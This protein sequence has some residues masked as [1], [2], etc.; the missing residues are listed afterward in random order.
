MK[1]MKLAVKLASG[2]GILIA[3]AVILGGMSVWQMSKVGIEAGH[4][5]AENVPM[6]KASLEAERGIHEAR[7]DIRI[8]S[9]TGDEGCRMAGV[10]HMDLT[11]QKLKEAQE[12]ADKYPGLTLLRDNIRKAADKT[13]EY[14]ILIAETVSRNKALDMVHSRQNDSAAQFMA[15]CYAFLDSQNRK[16]AAD[17]QVISAAANLAE[18]VS[19]L[20]ERLRKVSLMNDIIDAGNRLRVAN[21]K[22]Q[23]LGD[24][25][26]TKTAM[27]DFDVI[28]TKCAELAPIV[29]TQANKD[30]LAVIR[31]AAEQYKEA[32]AD[33]VANRAA[34]TELDV[35]RNAL[36]DA[37]LEATNANAVACIEKVSAMA[38]QS[39]ANLD[40]AA[41]AMLIG[42]ALAILLG[43]FITIILTREITKPILKG[44]EFANELAKGNFSQRLEI[45][46]RDEIGI[47]A[48]SLNTVVENLQIQIREIKEAAN[49]LAASSSEISASVSQVTSGAQ[50]TAAAV[51]QTTATVEE[52]KQG[53]HLTSQ[54]TRTVAENSQKGLQLAH[55]G[56]KAT[57]TVAEGMTHIN[58]QMASIADTIVKLGEQSQMIGEI[59]STVDD[60]AEQSN[61]LA[62]NAAVEAA[63]A[64]E[65]GKGFAVVAQE[66]KA[67]AEQSKQAT[68]QV[69]GILHDIQKATG[70]AVMATEQGSKAVEQGTK[71]SMSANES[72]QTLSLSFTETVQS[73]GQIAASTQEQ[74]TGMDQVALAMESIKEASQQNVASMKQLETAAQSLKDIGRKFSD[75]VG[76]YKV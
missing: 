68:K 70:A 17:I 15:N 76:R 23:A 71:E 41:R 35:K 30:E 57:E 33:Y 48:R 60:I 37:A 63:K 25:S 55:T 50:E 9:L 74:L 73:A 7:Y 20:N 29:K 61:L 32:M 38:T 6:F 52:V 16:F 65:H 26:I 67:L 34:L 49:V 62:V 66:I 1:N 59:T 24:N 56:R 53:A 58:E 3:G 44:V 43:I 42:L 27:K 39:S 36:S 28:E 18:Q 54:K 46:Q 2:F 40:Q 21:W 45:D 19:V 10:P 22:T 64:G 13:A 4:L 51:T 72:I 12:L 5:S 47:L 31:R 75:L 11:R 8:Y 14:N 69:R